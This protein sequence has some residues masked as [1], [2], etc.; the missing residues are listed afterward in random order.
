[1]VLDRSAGVPGGISIVLISPG[2]VDGLAAMLRQVRA[3]TCPWQEVVVC[4]SRARGPALT[5]ALRHWNME[6]PR[7]RWIQVNRPTGSLACLLQSLPGLRTRYLALMEPGDEWDQ[8]FLERHLH[9]LP[10][11]RPASGPRRIVEG[12]LRRLHWRRLSGFF[13]AVWRFRFSA[14]L[15]L[16]PGIHEVFPLTAALP[17]LNGSQGG[18]KGLAAALRWPQLAWGGVEPMLAT[19]ARQGRGD[20]RPAGASRGEV[21]ANPAA[22]EAVPDWSAGRLSFSQCGED[23]IADF[24]FRVLGIRY[25]SYLDIGA[26]HP[27]LYSNTHYFY[28]CGSRGVNVEA[29]PGLIAAFE[30]E[31]SLDVNLNVG[32]AAGGLSPGSS[33]PFY[34]LSTPTLNTFDREEAE[35][36]QAMGTH[37][38]EKVIEVPAV[39]VMDLIREHFP[40]QAPDFL[41][42]DVEGLDLAILQEIDFR[43][44]RPVVICVETIEFSENR[45]GV[46]LVEII[47]FLQGQGYLLYAD[48]MVNSI[49]VDVSRWRRKDS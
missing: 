27:R 26:H 31:R 20:A 17:R 16:R 11:V 15:R 43:K 3:Q 33:L 21:W 9:A 1:M 41:S 5:H 47:A 45:D 48:T 34:V 13:G 38:I 22:A 39:G 44:C 40:D 18:L 29:D 14:R 25:P 37:R 32:V 42:L 35:R 2:T 23:M 6:D 4:D 30:E 12:I 8:E 49:F 46:K 10:V 19:E 36:C 7:I 24:V 28:Q